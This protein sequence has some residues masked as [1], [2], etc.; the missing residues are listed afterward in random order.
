MLTRNN[1]GKKIVI[2]FKSIL[3]ARKRMQGEIRETPLLS[4]PFLDQMAGRRVLVKAECLQHTG[5]FKFR[6]AWSAISA[7]SEEKRKKGIIAYSSGNHAQGIA[8]VGKLFDSPVVIIMPEDAPTLKIENTRS[9]GAEI[10]LYDRVKQSREELGSSLAKNRNLTLIKP[11]DNHDVIAGQGTLGVE[12]AAQLS[13]YSL[14][15]IDVLVCCGGG[16][17]TAGVATALNETA[18]SLKVRPCEPVNYDDTLRSLKTGK[19]EVNTAS[20]RS[21]C[22]AILTPTPGEITFPILMKLAGEGLAVSEKEV[23]VSMAKAFQYLKLIVEPGGAVALASALF[24]KDQLRGD[25]VVAVLTGG[26]TDIKTF[27]MALKTLKKG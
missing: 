14:K 25:T 11:Y 18:P 10:I 27:N 16:G 12:L 20:T 13:Q 8:A 19:R 21:I 15:N 1:Q 4:S 3:E 24:R 9:Y 5:S 2:S 22:D 23:L 17:L 6:G 7:L 26:N